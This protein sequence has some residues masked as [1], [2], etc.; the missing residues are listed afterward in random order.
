MI[1]DF[2]L[3]KRQITEG[4]PLTTLKFTNEVFELWS[5]FLKANPKAR[6]EGGGGKG[7]YQETCWAQLHKTTVSQTLNQA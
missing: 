1:L 4:V 7:Y 2:T 3:V 6:G 5:L